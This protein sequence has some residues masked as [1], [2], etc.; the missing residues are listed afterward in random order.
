NYYFPETIANAPGHKPLDAR[1]LPPNGVQTTAMGWEVAPQGLTEL[2]V[3]IQRDYSPGPIYITENGSCYDD[4]VS[5]E[6]EVR[7]VERRHY[8]MRHLEALKAAIAAGVPVKGY[9]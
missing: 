4:T 9:F 1:V 7:D 3:R 6:G 8:L 2:L 5:P